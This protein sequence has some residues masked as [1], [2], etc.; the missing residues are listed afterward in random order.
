MVQG[1][2]LILVAVLV[3]GLL[4]TAGA[5]LR[6]ADDAARAF[7]DVS[8]VVGL[9]G[10]DVRTLARV[11]AE[12][13][14]G[15]AD[16]VALAWRQQVQS[17]GRS[18]PLVPAEARGIGCDLATDW[19]EALATDSVDHFLWAESTAQAFASLNTSVNAHLLTRDFDEAFRKREAGEP[20]ALEL[21]LIKASACTALA[22]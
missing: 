14:S 15:S 4:G 22:Q 19:L 13:V 7:D 5:C 11:E 8:R 3:V 10:D 18:Y 16:E 2:A 17:A 12:A 6:G 20:Y 1:R 21:F 9:S